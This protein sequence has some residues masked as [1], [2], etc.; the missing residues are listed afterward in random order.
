MCLEVP[1][2]SWSRMAMPK[3]STAYI[4]YQAPHYLVGLVVSSYCA[5]RITPLH[6][7]AGIYIISGGHDLP[8]NVFLL[9]VCDV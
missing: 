8:K 5:A 3:G 6:V 2:Q 1:L 9:G 7:L 4:F